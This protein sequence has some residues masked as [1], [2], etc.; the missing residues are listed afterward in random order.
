MLT[1]LPAGSLFSTVSLSAA[2]EASPAAGAT[3]AGDIV[4]TAKERVEQATAHV[5][6]WDGPTSGPAA[7]T[8]KTIVYVS[9]DQRN[10]G[11]A[12]VGKGV[13]E[14]ANAI[15]WKLTTIDGQGT[16]TGQTAALSQAIAL[17]P[18]GIVL[19][20]VDATAM[21]T[22]VQQAADQGITVV[23]WHG[24]A[25]AGP[26]PDLNLFTNIQSNPDD[27]ATITADYVIAQTDG[28]AQV[29]ILTDSQYQI[30]V[31]KSSAMRDEIERCAG[32]A[33]LSY[34]DTPLADVSTRMAPL[35]TSYLQRFGDTLNWILGINDLYFDFAAPALSAAG[36]PPSGPPQFVSAGDGSVSAYERIRAGQYQAATI[37]EPLN[38]HG[39]QAVDELNRA[40][41]GEDA[42]GYV[43]P[44]HL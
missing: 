33:V 44:V 40:F 12:G 29:A 16:V 11:A 34:D 18:D 28:N 25:D 36:I 10:G 2:Q 24:A 14:A 37:P 41:A 19:G 43:T 42:S 17:Q 38:L 7:Q 22:L 21:K 23:A 9:T 3:P 30:A 8:D 1:A 31:K 35:T 27:T 32:C 5:T 15:G 13:E 39:W 6:T 4:A 20:G 26:Q